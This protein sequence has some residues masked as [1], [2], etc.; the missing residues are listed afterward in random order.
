MSYGDVTLS[1]DP[2]Q[3]YLGLLDRAGP[4]VASSQATFPGDRVW[5]P[6]RRGSPV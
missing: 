3:V 1:V 6:A 4:R 2:F 5:T